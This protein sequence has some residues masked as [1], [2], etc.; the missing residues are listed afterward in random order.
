MTSATS[1]TAAAMPA[2]GARSRPRGAVASSAR[3]SLWR[4][5]HRAGGVRA[6][7]ARARGT[8]R[9]GARCP[10]PWAAAQQLSNCAYISRGER[11]VSLRRAASVTRTTTASAGGRSAV[12]AL[13]WGLVG[14]LLVGDLATCCVALGRF[15]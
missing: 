10:A 3:R 8:C 4:R 14:V 11:R 2:P 12:R 1:M 6:E 13:V 7:A 9:G 5:G 15:L